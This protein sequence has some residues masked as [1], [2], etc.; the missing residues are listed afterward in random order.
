MSSRPHVCVC[1]QRLVRARA[2]TSAAI[3]AL[4]ASAA[5][6]AL[7]SAATPASAAV[8]VSPL[9]RSADAMPGTQISF[10]G[11]PASALR[12][13]RVVGSMSGRH[14]GR[15]RSYASATGASF[16][17]RTGFTPGERVSVSARLRTG[18]RTERL[19]TSFTVAQPAAIPLAEFTAGP[20]RASEAQS[21]RSEPGLHPPVVTVHRPATSASAPGYLFA[22]PFIGPGQYGPM[23]FDNG[24]NL[25]WFRALPPGEDAG[26]LR[27]Q[28][29]RG[30]TVLTW[31]QG[32]TWT[33]GYGQGVD[34]IANSN[35]KT[36]AVIKAGNG[37]QAD[38]HELL[39]TPNGSAFVL[40]YSPVT[41]N[42]T[43][44]GGG[45]SGIALDGVIQEI[46]P[47]TGLVMWEWHSLGHVD[48]SES[49]SSLPGLAT[50]PFDYFHI[51][52][53]DVDR[54]GNILISAR[55]TW[56][57]YEINARTGGVTWRLGG[58]KSTFAL[59]PG[60]AFAWQ[61]NALFLENGEISV[62]DDEGSPPVKPPSRGE[63][64]KL[65][66]AAKTAT[67]VI[68]FIRSPAAL[69][70]NSQGN[71]Q[72][73]PGERWLIGWGGVPNFTEFNSKGEVIFDAQLPNA[74]LAGGIPSGE[75]SYR[76]Y[77]EPWSGQPTAYNPAIAVRRAGGATAV[78]ASWNGATDI[79]SWQLLAGPDA[80][81]LSP[82]GATT[83]RSGFE[84]TIPAPAAAY[85][86]VR[87]L[88][89]SGK[90]LA[91]SKA[92]AAAGA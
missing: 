73:L 83:P 9:P 43:A 44:A 2:I 62:F 17:P 6:V 18:R 26:D 65:N 54:H 13:I 10:L 78:Y 92:V 75:F 55:N 35:Y 45:A 70:T 86:E 76:V 34:V 3:V 11:A 68:Q 31:W 27:T 56:T 41:T 57:I 15:L 12:S 46:D 87:A 16:I 29:Y 80:N 40:A 67:L 81:H 4:A 51:N 59:G 5:I 72:Q 8:T 90:V 14:S 82:T 42:L 23:I 84:T 61:H 7:F 32:R 77:R 85:Y 89:A 25:V 60:V 39:L 50:N 52:S 20:S 37:L 74:T 1:A 69:T 24:G 71:L 28:T 38:E 21:F 88:S 66:A 48:V 49:Y 47:R 53:L 19:A 79:A 33:F 36:V 91:S 63:V 64:I 22:T 58:K 30:Q